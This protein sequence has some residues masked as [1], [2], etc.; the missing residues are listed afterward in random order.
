MKNHETH[1]KVTGY[2]EILRFADQIPP[3]PSSTLKVLEM[4]DDPA[5]DAIELADAVSVDTKLTMALLKLAYS[6][7]YPKPNGIRSVA[8]AI[9][10]VGLNQLQALTLTTS[11]I[12]LAK[13]ETVDHLVWENSVATAIIARRLAEEI[14][15]QHPEEIFLMGLLHCLGQFA[16]LANPKTSLAYRGVL[17]RIQDSG[18]DYVTA[19]LEVIG[20]S[21]NMIGALVANRWN[22]SSELCETILHYTD[23]V[24]PMVSHAGQKR[25]LVK[26]AD[27]LAH[28]ALVGRP[29]GY[30]IQ[31]ELIQELST[32]LGIKCA[33]DHS[34]VGLIVM[35]RNQLQ[36]EPDFWTS[37]AVR[38]TIFPGSW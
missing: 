23:P 10:V 29:Q 24:K 32:V 31:M 19:E 34:A 6:P 3:L 26:L 7:A 36:A 13:C 12:G 15:T 14:A 30:P 25:L 38:R 35:A 1:T 9:T 11:L 5:S 28:A 2:E 17:Q 18:V 27:L 37:L 16:L 20:F 33:G 4:L 8:E 22:F 21:H